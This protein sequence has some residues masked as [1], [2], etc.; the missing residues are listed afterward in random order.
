[1]DI[2]TKN[3]KWILIVDD[4][5]DICTSLISLFTEFLGSDVRFQTAKD[6]IEATSKISQQKFDCII[7]DLNM[8]RKEGV[9]LI[10]SIRRNVLNE[11]TPIIVLSGKVETYSLDMFDYLIIVE[12]PY[13]PNKLVKIVEDQL[14]VKSN[15]SRIPV[16]GA[17]LIYENINNFFQDQDGETEISQKRAFLKKQGEKIEHRFVVRKVIDD[18]LGF[19]VIALSVDKPFQP[20]IESESSG[21]DITKGIYRRL[22][23]FMNY[24]ERKKSSRNPVGTQLSIENGG[25]ESFIGVAFEF[26]INSHQFYIFTSAL[27]TN[28]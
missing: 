4:E 24:A 11:H 26:E 19:R 22:M 23:E 20:V 13:D 18:D 5:E 16:N 1:M 6:G 28:T 7:T 17:N 3:L 15:K 2:E 10:N 12:K 9:S 25:L 27:V 8:P 21:D 14:K